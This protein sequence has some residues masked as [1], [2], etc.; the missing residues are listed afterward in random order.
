MHS[1]RH[2]CIGDASNDDSDKWVISITLCV[3]QAKVELL[4]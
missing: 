2:F 3:S 1:R 4:Y